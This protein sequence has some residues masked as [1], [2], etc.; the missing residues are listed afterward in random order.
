MKPL[1]RIAMLCVLLLTTV[2]LVFAPSSPAQATTLPQCVGITKGSNCGDMDATD[3]YGYVKAGET[4]TVNLSALRNVVLD[5][6][7]ITAKLYKPSG[8]LYSTKSFTANTVIGD[9]LILADNVV[10]DETGLWLLDLSIGAAG[11]NFSLHDWEFSIK[12]NGIDLPGRVFTEFL[13]HYINDSTYRMPEF[14]L[15]TINDTGHI[16]KASMKLF[17]GVGS[18]FVFDSKGVVDTATGLPL[19]KSVPATDPKYDY[20]VGTPY[21]IFFEPPADDLPAQ[22]S[23]A[24]G[25]KLVKPPVMEFAKIVA[26]K[27]S[28]SPTSFANAGGEFTTVFD[29][30]FSGNYSLRIDTNNYNV[31]T[32]T[33]DVSVPGTTNGGS[34]TVVWNGKNGQ[35]V[36]LGAQAFNSQIFVEKYGEMH[37]V[38]FDVEG[39]VEGITI[40]ALTEVAPGRKYLVNWDDSLIEQC[41]AT[42]TCPR[43]STTPGSKLNTTDPIIGVDVDSSSGAHRWEYSGNSWGDYSLIDDWVYAAKDSVLPNSTVTTPA[44][45]SVKTDNF[46]AVATKASG[47]MPDVGDKLTA[48]VTLKNEGNTSQTDVVVAAANGTTVNVGTMAAN[49]TKT[50]TVERTLTQADVDAFTDA[51]VAITVTRKNAEAQVK[52]WNGTVTWIPRYEPSATSSATGSNSTDVNNNGIIDAGDVV[53]ISYRVTNTGNVTLSDLE[54]SSDSSAASTGP[55]TL[56][57]STSYTYTINHTVTASEASNAALR[58]MLSFKSENPNLEI[59]KEFVINSV[60]G[61]VI[62]EPEYNLTMTRTHTPDKNVYNE[63]EPITWTY[64]IA[65]HGNSVVTGLTLSDDQG[66]T[67]TCPK[68]SIGIGETMKCTG[69]SSVVISAR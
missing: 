31:F 57:P 20:G 5:K 3:L 36:L 65:N 18:S 48:Q 35:G 61:D 63:G 44:E 51:A 30:K 40:E 15:W 6:H 32:D 49:T 66:T 24:N 7:A 33:V 23:S 26:S 45:D 43:Q 14:S 29:S 58:V 8:T 11:N 54:A 50:V 53:E 68:T 60:A 13:N 59:S 34:S 62:T 19:Y 39:S 25:V 55:S 22:A 21:R 16:Y 2:I 17:N 12:R 1:R 69:V 10:S 64:T 4:V 9:T 67:L 27:P 47:S 28:Y 56:S 37:L 38:R 52:T 41:N 42:A 46:T